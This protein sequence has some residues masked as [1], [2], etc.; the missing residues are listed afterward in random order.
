V[1]AV[2]VDKGLY[3]VIGSVFNLSWGWGATAMLRQNN[4]LTQMSQS[5]V[6]VFKKPQHSVPACIFKDVLVEP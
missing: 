1:R 6:F 4:S 5:T 2:Y 3:T